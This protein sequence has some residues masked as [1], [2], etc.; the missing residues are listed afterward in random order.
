MIRFR[1]ERV[2]ETALLFQVLDQDEKLR[3]KTGIIDDTEYLKFYSNNGIIIASNNFPGIQDI[4][5]NFISIRGYNRAY[6][7]NVSVINFKSLEELIVYKKR[8]LEAFNQ[9]KVQGGFF[10]ENESKPINVD[11]II[12]QY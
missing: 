10:T 1:L 11:E 8:V 12:Y 5:K 3:F 7:K 9:F 6:D 2:C 4:D